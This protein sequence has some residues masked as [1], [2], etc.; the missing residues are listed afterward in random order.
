MRA[1]LS[2]T[3]LKDIYSRIAGRYDLQHALITAGA[4]QRGRKLLVEKA[5]G[6]G[7]SVLDCGAGTG[8]TAAL[9]ARKVGPKGRV[10]LLDLTDAMLKVARRK[11]GEAG[12][13]DRASFRT[14]DI[15]HL[16][17]DSDEFDV[18]LST[19]SMCPLY[20]PGKGALELYRVTRPGGRI[21]VAHS[22]E[23][24]NRLARWLSERVE[25][26]AWHFPSLSMGCRSVE[27]LPT[28]QAAG[29]EVLFSKRVGVPSWPFI[30]FVI[31]KPAA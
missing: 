2:V 18:V 9:A 10:V 5:V 26:W 1:A 27:V 4:D 12:L 30:V 3:Q 23:P 20:D 21:G 15:V 7:D 11:L 28:L 17:F 6:E 22:T 13:L 29:G 19:Y 25:T 14:G 24:A 31:G 8:T 16:P